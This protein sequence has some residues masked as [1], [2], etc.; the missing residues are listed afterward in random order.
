[1]VREAIKRASLKSAYLKT[2]PDAIKWKIPDAI[3][4]KIPGTIPETP[5]T[6][7]D[8]IPENDTWQKLSHTVIS[9]FLG[10]RKVDT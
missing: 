3:K 7:P 9:I 6:I 4:W 8:T 5:K 2:I 10:Y 1:M